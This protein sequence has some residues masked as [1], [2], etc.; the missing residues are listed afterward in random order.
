MLELIDAF[1]SLADVLYYEWVECQIVPNNQN[2]QSFSAERRE[3]VFPKCIKKCSFDRN[4]WAISFLVKAFIFFTVTPAGAN[5]FQPPCDVTFFFGF[6]I[7]VIP[8]PI[9]K[10][11]DVVIPNLFDHFIVD[12]A[13][14]MILHLNPALLSPLKENRSKIVDPLSSLLCCFGFK[15]E[16]SLGSGNCETERIELFRHF[17]FSHNCWAN[18]KS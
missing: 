14:V 15:I 7:F 9:P 1:L 11:K 13:V 16:G 4:S 18:S 8:M 5:G 17:I 10:W 2:P 6:P 12:S 3:A